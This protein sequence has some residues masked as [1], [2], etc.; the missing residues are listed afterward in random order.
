MIVSTLRPHGEN[1]I[2]A[3]HQKYLFI[4]NLTGGHGAIAQ[5]RNRKSIFQI[6]LRFFAHS[7]L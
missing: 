2:A 7:L 1:L 6:G 4:V 3:S 5:I